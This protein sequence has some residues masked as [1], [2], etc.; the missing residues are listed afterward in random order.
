MG[1]LI[2]LNQRPHMILCQSD[3]MPLG[4]LR[5]NYRKRYW[6]ISLMH[7]RKNSEISSFNHG[8]LVEEQ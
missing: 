2:K 4:K 8:S 7:R 1:I 5:Y 3:V 6:D